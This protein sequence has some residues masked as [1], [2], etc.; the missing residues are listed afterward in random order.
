MSRS[1]TF[2]RV[3]L[4]AG[5]ALLSCGF[6]G[7][8]RAALRENARRRVAIAEL[9]RD[10]IMRL[11]FEPPGPGFDPR[12]PQALLHGPWITWS[13]RLREARRD[14]ASGPIGLREALVVHRDEI[15]KLEDSCREQARGG[16][17]G[18]T[19]VD[20]DQMI[21]LRLE[22]EAEMIRAGVPLEPPK[23]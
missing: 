20:L 14:A 15:R 1:P 5:A 12:R 8:D 16:A 9:Q 4:L 18:V 13:R 7:G 6:V 19:P 23:D 11:L 10:V 22:D 2:R 17:S 3:V 21:Y